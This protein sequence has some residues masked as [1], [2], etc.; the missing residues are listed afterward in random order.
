MSLWLAAGF[1]LNQEGAM[2]YV[3]LGLWLVA[4]VIYLCLRLWIVIQKKKCEEH[5]NRLNRG[6]EANEKE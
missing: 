5:E 1:N 6:G 4:I 2:L 3:E